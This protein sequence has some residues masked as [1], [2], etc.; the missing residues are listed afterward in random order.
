MDIWNQSTGA[1]LRE[2]RFGVDDV[3][4]TVECLREFPVLHLLEPVD[5][6]KP[7]D[8]REMPMWLAFE[9]D[10]RQIVRVIAP[11]W[12]DQRTL[13]ELVQA[14]KDEDRFQPVPDG[15][16][17]IAHEFFNKANLT[18]SHRIF[19][20]GKKGIERAMQLIEDLRFQREKKILAGL[21]QLDSETKRINVINMSKIEIE[22]W[23]HSFQISMNCFRKIRTERRTYDGTTSQFESNQTESA[24]PN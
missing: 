5:S 19:P 3:K 11:S 24:T 23:R 22:T 1:A 21:N 13:E 4:I 18:Q 15:Y 10:K 2:F 14:E 6:M 8:L 16:L 20:G 7:G 9:M 12:L 17:Q